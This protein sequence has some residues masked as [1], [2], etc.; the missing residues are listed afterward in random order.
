M[1]EDREEAEEGSSYGNKYLAT[2]IGTLPWNYKE[3]AQK[4]VPDHGIIR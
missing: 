4:Q 1:H 2:K 3:D